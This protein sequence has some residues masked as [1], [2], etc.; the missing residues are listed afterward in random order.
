MRNSNCDDLV[1]NDIAEQLVF[2]EVGKKLKVIFGCG[3]EGFRDHHM[4]DEAG[5]P[6][7]RNDKK[8]LIEEWLKQDVSTDRR[9]YVWNKVINFPIFFSVLFQ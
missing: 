1:V 4:R 7:R 6:G 9:H 8:D 5:Y 3:R 2:G